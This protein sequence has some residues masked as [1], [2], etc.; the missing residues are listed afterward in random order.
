MFFSLVTSSYIK[1]ALMPAC[2]NRATS[3]MRTSSC[4][5]AIVG[6]SPGLKES[7]VFVAGLPFDASA[8]ERPVVEVEG[9]VEEVKEV[10]PLPV[11]TT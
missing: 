1:S 8:D 7:A 4:A 5:D 2:H 9:R 10:G 11:L 6:I 3:R